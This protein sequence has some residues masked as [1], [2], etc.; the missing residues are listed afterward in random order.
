MGGFMRMALETGNNVFACFT[1]G[2]EAIWRQSM[3]V[4]KWIATMLKIAK[5]VLGILPPAWL[6]VIPNRVPL[7]TV[8][9]VPIDLSDLRPKT[10][11]AP[12]TQSSIDEGM[13]RYAA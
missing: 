11:G 1:F 6:Q 7:T 10:P 5:E 2:D 8:V 9:G 4:P 3:S 13:Q 12:V